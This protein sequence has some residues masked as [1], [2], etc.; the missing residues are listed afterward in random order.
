MAKPNTEATQDQST[1]D[2]KKFSE[3]KTSGL[4]PMVVDASYLKFEKVGE[5]NFIAH[6]IKTFPKDGEQVEVVQ[7]ENPSEGKNFVNG[8]TLLVKAVKECGKFPCFVRI[9][10]KGKKATQN[11]DMDDLEIFTLGV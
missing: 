6:G 1:I 8:S 2:F 5:Y 7:L 3:M 9:I 4:K 10:F 11:G